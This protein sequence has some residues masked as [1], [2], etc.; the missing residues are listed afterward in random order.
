MGSWSWEVF[1]TENRSPKLNVVSL[2]V[3][4]QRVRFFTLSQLKSNFILKGYCKLSYLQL[5]CNLQT[6]MYLEQKYERK[7]FR[8]MDCRVQFVPGA[9]LGLS[10]RMVGYMHC[11]LVFTCQQSHLQHSEPMYG[12]A[13]WKTNATECAGVNNCMHNWMRLW[14][15]YC[16]R[17]FYQ[18]TSLPQRWETIGAIH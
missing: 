1:S 9:T 11:A 15:K 5:Q 13:V 16:A 10:F 8:M 7:V 4:E 18:R 2:S 17:L 6:K 14:N 3:W 12:G